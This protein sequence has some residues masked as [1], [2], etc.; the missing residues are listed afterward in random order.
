M[1]G[2]LTESPAGCKQ[3]TP[4]DASASTTVPDA[5]DATKTHAPMMLTTDIALR[6]DPIYEPISRRFQKDPQAFRRRLRTGV[7]QTDPPGHGTA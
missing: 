7:V 6:T 4:T 5:H 1:S 3:W 2:K